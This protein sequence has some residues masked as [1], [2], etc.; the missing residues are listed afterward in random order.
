MPRDVA[1]TRAKRRQALDLRMAGVP[2]DRIATELGY[3][4][5]QNARRVVLQALAENE[6]ESVKELRTIEGATLDRAQRA[7]WPAVIAGDIEAVRALVRISAQRA[8]LFGLYAPTKIEV[9]EDVDQ[10]IG[11]IAAA[12][13]AE[14]AGDGTFTVTDVGGGDDDG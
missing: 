6:A 7:I 4:N 5:K 11:A 13:V 9:S 14:Q 8:R 2:Y 3:A 1:A 12:L 10:Q